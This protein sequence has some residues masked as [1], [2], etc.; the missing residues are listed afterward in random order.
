MDLTYGDPW[1]GE[2]YIKIKGADV[3]GGVREYHFYFNDG[4]AVDRACSFIVDCL[5]K[6]KIVDRQEVLEKFGDRF[7]YMDNYK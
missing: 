2:Y 7:V 5:S 1:D 4:H 3:G 6:M